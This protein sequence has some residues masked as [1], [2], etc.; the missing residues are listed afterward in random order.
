ME[1]IKPTTGLSIILTEDTLAEAAPRRSA[2]LLPKGCELLTLAQVD[3]DNHYM[4]TSVG[5]FTFYK[6]KLDDNWEFKR[7]DPITRA[8]LNMQGLP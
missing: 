4:T 5:K 3:K 8:Y 2:V 7:S 1:S 6:V